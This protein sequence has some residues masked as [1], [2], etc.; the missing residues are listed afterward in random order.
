MELGRRKKFLIWRWWNSVSRDIADV[1]TTFVRCLIYLSL[2]PQPYPLSGL[3]ET[4]YSFWMIQTFTN[5]K[6]WTGWSLWIL[7]HLHFC[8]FKS[9]QFFG[10]KW[11]QAGMM[12]VLAER[13]SEEARQPF[14]LAL[15]KPPATLW[16]TIW[17]MGMT[18]E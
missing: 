8:L 11:T 12:K 5:M 10:W 13:D 2:L 18:L 16:Q 3:Q 7:H 9:G 17:T 15:V 1:E 14:L 6:D 4:K